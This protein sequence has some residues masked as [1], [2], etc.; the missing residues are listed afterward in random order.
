M[1]R[2]CILFSFLMI[3][4]AVMQAHNFIPHHHAIETV[5]S[6]HHHDQNEEH[7]QLPF[8]DLTHDADFGKVIVKPQVIK[9]VD[10]KIITFSYCF[11]YECLNGE[12]FIQSKQYHPPD[13][14]F[15]LHLIFLSH[16]VPL[17][18]PPAC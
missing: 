11:I 4:F 7:H 15:P 3:A 5:E 6:N 18:A 14:N 2:K 17:R 9:G 12:T 8:S 1:A 10:V 13:D 16:S